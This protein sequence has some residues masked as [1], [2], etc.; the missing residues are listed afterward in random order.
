MARLTYIGGPTALIEWRGLRLLTDP[1]FDPAGTRYELAGY[2][3][4]KTEG[5][6]LEPAQLGRLDAVLLSHDHHRD[7]LDDS[8]RGVLAAAACVLTTAEGAERLGGAA[9]GLQPCE[10][11]VLH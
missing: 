10:Q 9:R 11:A 1:T 2:A 3:L 5:P 4:A 6:A 7:N 8:G